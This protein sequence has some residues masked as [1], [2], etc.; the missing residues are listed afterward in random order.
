M[1][2]K[3]VLNL[4]RFRLN[5]SNELHIDSAELITNFVLLWSVYEKRFYA[6]TENTSCDQHRMLAKVNSDFFEGTVFK[7]YFDDFKTRYLEDE[8][9]FTSLRLGTGKPYSG[10]E[11]AI[12]NRF[13]SN[14]NENEMAESVLG[15]IYR[16]RNNLFHGV[17][18]LAE[19]NLELE[20]IEIANRCLFDVIKNNRFLD[21]R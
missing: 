6:V 21:E 7:P 3:T 15:I 9:K 4:I 2:T 17:K 11:D 13:M 19:Y 12:R 10:F 8:S 18:N 20:P 1:Q 5:L 14:P 16:L